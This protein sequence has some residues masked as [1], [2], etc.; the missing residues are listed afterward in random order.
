MCLIPRAVVDAV[1]AMGHIGG[2]GMRCVRW[3]GVV[4]R[5]ICSKLRDLAGE[6]VRAVWRRVCRLGAIGPFDAAGRRFGHFGFGSMICFPAATIMNERHISLG[7]GTLICPQVSLSVGVIPGQQGL[8]PTVLR[9]GDRCVLGRGSSIVAH[10]RVEIGDD[11]WTGPNVY[12]TDQ[13]HGYTDVERPIWQQPTP[14]DRAVV[15]GAGSWL[16]YGVVVLPGARI[17]RNAVIGA[18][19]VVIGDIPDWSVAVGVPAR[20][21]RRYVAGEGWR[22]V[23]Q[24]PASRAAA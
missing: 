24:P 11:V 13:N 19:A 4:R 21:V 16:G 18:H 17:G 10:T 20:V 6:G 5:R 14:P 7:S 8:D 12:I 15:V 1:V 23:T 22:P 2:R 3:I 9:I